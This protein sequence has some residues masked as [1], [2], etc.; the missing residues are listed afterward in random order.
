MIKRSALFCFLILT[1]FLW[2]ENNLRF[3]SLRS[4]APGPTK[5][6]RV[7]GIGSY[8]WD[9]IQPVS[10][11]LLETIYLQKKDWRSVTWKEFSEMLTLFQ[12]YPE[13]TIKTGGST[14]NTMKGLAAFGISAALTGNVGLDKRGDEL[15]F[16]ME[17]A[18]VIPLVTRTSTP[19]SQIACLIT[20][21][22]ER[23]FCS[24]VEA[25]SEITCNDLHPSYF[26]KTDL[27]HIEG[28]LLRNHCVVDYAMQLAQKNG[29]LVSYDLCCTQLGEKYRERLWALLAEYVDIFFCDSDEAYSLTHLPPKEACVFL[30][31][32]C[33]IVVVKIGADGCWVA[34]REKFFHCPAIPANSVDTTGAGDLFASGFL[35]GVLEGYSLE[36]AAYFGSVCGSAVVEQPG[37]EIPENRW[38]EIVKL[39][40]EH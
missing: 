10:D 7:L 16:A 35:Y 20:P 17:S 22:G 15:I 18:G 37:G 36:E 5:E 1:S 23:S 33:P 26:E 40:Q 24:F 6:Y 39:I 9:Y 2:G 29:A 27:V 28:Y 30:K 8:S 14:A 4:D 13:P 32:F 21:D 38:T 3:F 31:N 19:T 12:C 25:E 11:Q 34:S